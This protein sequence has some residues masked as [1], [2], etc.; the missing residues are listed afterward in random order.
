LTKNILKIFTAVSG[1]ELIIRTLFSRKT[2]LPRNFLGGN[3]RGI[4]GKIGHTTSA[5][6]Y[7]YNTGIVEGYSVY[8]KVEENLFILN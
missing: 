5:F 7:N 3:Y 8:S 6:T 4:S 1:L 2:D